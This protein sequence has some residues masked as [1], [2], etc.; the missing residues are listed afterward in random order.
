MGSDPTDRG[1]GGKIV[2]LYFYPQ[3]CPTWELSPKSET[4]PLS[5]VGTEGLSA[6]NGG[7][8]N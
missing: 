3:C 5:E 7:L 4:I 1:P 2:A 6:L 8:E